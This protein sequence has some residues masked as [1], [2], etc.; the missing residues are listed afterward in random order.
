MTNLVRCLLLLVVTSLGASG[1]SQ[2][3]DEPKLWAVV[4][5][6]EPLTFENWNGSTHALSIEFGLVNDSDEVVSTGAGSWKIVING[7]ELADSDIIFGNGPGPSTGWG[8]L[9]PGTSFIFGKSLP[10]NEYFSKPGI[11]EVTW[12]GSQFA[13]RPVIVRVMPRP[14]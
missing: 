3:S 12:K 7:Q 9:Q 8:T 13:A 4:G 14:K 2:T 10:M 11:Y 1:I 6:T 5:V